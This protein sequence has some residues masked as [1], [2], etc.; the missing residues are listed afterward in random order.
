MRSLRR[1]RGAAMAA[2][3]AFQTPAD[4]C[5]RRAPTCVLRDIFQ[6]RDG[7]AAAFTADDIDRHAA[8]S[9]VPERPWMSRLLRRHTLVR[10]E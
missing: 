3:A 8:F 4:F 2:V 1:Q 9:Q 5:S 10:D 7:E 6:L